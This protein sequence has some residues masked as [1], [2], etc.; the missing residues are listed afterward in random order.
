MYSQQSTV[1]MVPAL[2]VL[3][4]LYVFCSQRKHLI[5]T[6]LSIEGMVISLFFI[7]SVNSDS[8]SAVFTF[9][10]LAL[11][12]CEA[13]LGLSVLVAIVRTHSNDFVSSLGMAHTV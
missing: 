3:T 9:V 2:G 11:A 4:S 5:A 10:F 12:V 6:L 1:L 7:I 8:M 13:A